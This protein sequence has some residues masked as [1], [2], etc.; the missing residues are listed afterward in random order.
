MERI[1]NFHCLGQDDDGHWYLFQLKRRARFNQLVADS[2]WETLAAEFE[3]CR[4]S[5]SPFDIVFPEFY[6][7]DFE[8]VV[9]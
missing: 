9:Q 3:E 1:A 2:D 4:L 5:G 8:K 7:V 6:F